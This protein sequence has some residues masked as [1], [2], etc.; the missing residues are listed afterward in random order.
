[1]PVEL[2]DQ[3]IE[4]SVTQDTRIAASI[5]NGDTSVIT[6]IFKEWEATPPKQLSMLSKH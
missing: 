1:M 3:F 4:H 2:V 5:V 6:Q